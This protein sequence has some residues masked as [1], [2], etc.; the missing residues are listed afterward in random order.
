MVLPFEAAPTDHPE[1]VAIRATGMT[2]SEAEPSNNSTQST[3][4]VILASAE[5]TRILNATYVF[6]S[7]IRS[8]YDG[9][10]GPS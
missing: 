2:T 7:D 6:P 10:F 3:L 9:G 5:D 4:E 8:A 1:P